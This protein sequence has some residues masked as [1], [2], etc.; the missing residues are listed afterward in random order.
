MIPHPILCATKPSIFDPLSLV[1]DMS[2]QDWV[3]LIHWVVKLVEEYRKS[4]ES[5]YIEYSTPL[6]KKRIE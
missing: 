1:R 2:G 5:R 4:F 6:K 3:F